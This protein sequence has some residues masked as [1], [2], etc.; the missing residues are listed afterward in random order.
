MAQYLISFD[1][2]T[3]IIPDED[4][5]EVAAAAN[6]VCRDAENAGVWVVGGGLV[7]QGAS[8]VDVDGTITALPHPPTRAV[9]GGLVIVDVPSREEALEW[10][11]RFAAACRCA[12][13]VRELF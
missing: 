7:H 1:E 9:L 6:R 2:G 8:T 12:Q 11:S 10:A 5:P 13:D 3:M 4:L